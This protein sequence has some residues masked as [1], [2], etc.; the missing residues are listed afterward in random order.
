MYT[1]LRCF[2]QHLPPSRTT[3]YA[4]K[5]RN[6]IFHFPNHM[7][8][9]HF[10]SMWYHPKCWQCGITFPLYRVRSKSLNVVTAWSNNLMR[11]WGVEP[12]QDVDISAMYNISKFGHLDF[13]MPR[14]RSIYFVNK[15]V[16]SLL[17]VVSLLCE[18]S[19]NSSQSWIMTSRSVFVSQ[20]EGHSTC[21]YPC[22][23]HCTLYN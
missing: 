16:V 21:S 10:L 5:G 2:L 3:Q 1:K 19:T 15:S 20:V 18:K 4:Q 8:L 14:T 13:A 23:V 22:M 7:F 6:R 17:F 9:S 11:S 12:K